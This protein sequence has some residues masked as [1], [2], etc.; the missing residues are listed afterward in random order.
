MKKKK[1]EKPLK[2]DVQI[3]EE[4]SFIFGRYVIFKLIEQQWARV[5]FS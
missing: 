2:M 3:Q 5:V 4:R 1:K